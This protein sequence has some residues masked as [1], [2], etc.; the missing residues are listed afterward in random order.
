MTKENGLKRL[1]DKILELEMAVVDLKNLRDGVSDTPVDMYER[2]IDDKFDKYQ[3]ICCV[4]GY[5]YLGDSTKIYPKQD[6]IF[7][8]ELGIY[9]KTGIL[10]ESEIEILNN[11][12]K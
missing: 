2:T 4:G 3:Y 10:T 9:S 11:T 7:A 6:M 8:P 1:N 12:K 5:G